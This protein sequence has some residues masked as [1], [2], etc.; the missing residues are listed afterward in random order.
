MEEKEIILEFENDKELAIDILQEEVKEIHP[1]YEQLDITPSIQKQEYKGSFDKVTVQAM[2]NLRPY[3]VTQEGS[4]SANTDI[5]NLLKMELVR[6]GY[7][8]PE[9]VVNND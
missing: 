5:I 6:K 7:M 2:E 3:I 8:T 9:E 4:I 1:I